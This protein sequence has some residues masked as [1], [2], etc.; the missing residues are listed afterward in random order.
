MFW[1]LNGTAGSPT[2]SPSPSATPKCFTES[3]Y[4]QTVDGHAYQ[5]GGYTYTNGSN[6]NMG[7]WN[8]FVTHT[9][10]ETS[11]GCYVIAD[12]HCS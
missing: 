10:E 7:L 12:S 6:Q 11:S 4:Q 1:G 5:S 8:L 9:L 3:N 2:P